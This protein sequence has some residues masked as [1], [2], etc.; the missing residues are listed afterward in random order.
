MDYCGLWVV[1]FRSRPS[2]QAP[3]VCFR[4]RSVFS[5]ANGFLCRG[6]GSSFQL[7]SPEASLVGSPSRISETPPPEQGASTAPDPPFCF[8]RVGRALRPNASFR[9][10]PFR[11]SPPLRLQLFRQPVAGMFRPLT[12]CS[13]IYSY[14]ALRFRAHR[15]PGFVPRPD[16]LRLPL[17]VTPATRNR[18]ACRPRD[19][20]VGLPYFAKFSVSLRLRK[21][22]FHCKNT[23]FCIKNQIKPLIFTIFCNNTWPTN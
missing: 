8:R 1:A 12:D 21:M 13:L 19:L 9:N 6:T 17:L 4:R 10:H 15:R 22:V 16:K 5:V 2:L 14:L 7:L 11:P 20:Y 23:I 3:A 18:S